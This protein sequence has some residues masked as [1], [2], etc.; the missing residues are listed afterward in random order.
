MKVRAWAVGALAASM[1]FAVPAASYAGGADNGGGGGN[2]LGGL[3]GGTLLGNGC[4][5]GELV[6][7]AGGAG[8]VGV[9]LQGLEGL[10]L[11]NGILG[12]DD[13]QLIGIGGQTD[14]DSGNAL[15]VTGAADLGNGLLG[16]TLGPCD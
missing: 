4:N 14:D 11:Y 5:E 8:L 9:N 2:L 15:I 12:H 6:T 3:F 16:I 7:V 10:K 1:I 13:G